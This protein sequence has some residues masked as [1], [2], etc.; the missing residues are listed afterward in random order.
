MKMSKLEGLQM[1]KLLDFPTV[2]II[3]PNLL[4]ENSAILKQ[5]LSVRTSPKRDL[6]NNVNL[7]SI[8]N[9]T[10]LQELRKFIQEHR[11]E[12][13]IIVHRTPKAEQ[14]GSVSRL[15]IGMDKVII[16]LF[17]DYEERKKGMIKNRVMFPVLGDK[18]RIDKLQ[19]DE[20]DEEEFKVFSKV[21]KDVK[22]MPFKQFDAEFVVEN[23]KVFFTDLTIQGKED[24]EYAEELR[25][26]AQQKSE[27]REVLEI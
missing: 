8:H 24:S 14:I 2:D 22:Y 7:P 11:D 9:C 6:Q 27:K 5:G 13:H 4:D 21:I 23:D 16:E 12:Y 20:K 1:L 26:K 15:E 3:D 19:I 18:F 25:K 17:R 10:D